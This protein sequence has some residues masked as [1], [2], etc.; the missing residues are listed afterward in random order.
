MKPRR[1]RLDFY[2]NDSDRRAIAR[3]GWTRGSHAEIEITRRGLATDRGVRYWM[4]EQLRIV[5]DDLTATDFCVHELGCEEAG[6][7]DEHDELIP[8]GD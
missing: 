6:P 5:L 1:I 3:L 4:E 7:H 2:V 8:A